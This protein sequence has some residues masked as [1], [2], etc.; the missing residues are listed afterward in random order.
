VPHLT[1]AFIH[2]CRGLQATPS[3][4][5]LIPCCQQDQTEAFSKFIEFPNLTSLSQV[6]W[7]KCYHLSRPIDRAR[8]RV[9]FISHTITLYSVVPAS[10]S[11]LNS[12]KLESINFVDEISEKTYG[13]QLQL[14][15]QQFP[16]SVI[17][18]VNLKS[19]FCFLKLCNT[20]HV[21]SYT[22]IVI[23]KFCFFTVAKPAG[24]GQTGQL[25]PPRDHDNVV[26]DNRNYFWML[27]LLVWPVAG[28]LAQNE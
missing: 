3:H 11:R 18:C 12:H 25:P 15:N 17:A 6:S 28:V 20:V 7:P 4:L 26:S 9:I 22:L 24:G 21:A 10:T 13:L 1:L 16:C 27:L 19:L 5:T 8:I 2:C 23:N 14:Y